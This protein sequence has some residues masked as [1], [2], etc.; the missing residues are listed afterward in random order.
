MESKLT[1]RTDEEMLA[2]VRTFQTRQRKWQEESD[3]RLKNRAS[4]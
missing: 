3:R 4:D 1:L 2:A